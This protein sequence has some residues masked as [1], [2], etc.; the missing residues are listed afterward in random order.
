METKSLFYQK[1]YLYIG[2]PVVESVPSYLSPRL[3]WKPKTFDQK[4]TYTLDYLWWNLSNWVQL[5]DLA[6]VLVFS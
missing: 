1:N 2:L 6:R 3:T 5:L 4:T